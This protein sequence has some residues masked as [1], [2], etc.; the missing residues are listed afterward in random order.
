VL[1]SLP[2]SLMQ[3]NGIAS[4]G[5]T[6]FIGGSAAGRRAKD[7]GKLKTWTQIVALHVN[8]IIIKNDTYELRRLFFS[9]L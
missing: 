2:M 8:I 3:G 5:L 9:F 7:S 4:R 1:E 6:K